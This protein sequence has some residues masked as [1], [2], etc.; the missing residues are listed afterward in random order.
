LSFA[1][2]SN[3]TLAVGR[4]GLAY[5]WGANEGALGEGTTSTR[6]SPYAAI[7][8]SDVVQ[9]SAGDTHSVAITAN[10]DVYT[11]GRGNDGRLGQ[12]STAQL[13]QPT[14]VMVSGSPFRVVENAF[15]AS[16]LDA[17][18][19][20]AWGEYRWDTDLFRL[21]SNGNGISDGDEVAQGSE[22]SAWDPDG[23]GVSNADEIVN[24]TDPLLFDTDGDGVGDGADLFPLD[25]TR[26]QL[27]PPNPCTGNPPPPNCD[28]TPP[29]V[30]ITS[31]A[32]AVIRP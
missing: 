4:D 31:P 17:D 30:T 14:R 29:T 8:I 7:G 15:L 11:W 22:P 12:G 28:G 6:L 25:P 16:D 20:T 27:P 3:F 19:L 5:G 9:V 13:L 10:G 2:G 24:G 1:T 18:G 23:D 26:S 21:D 32:N